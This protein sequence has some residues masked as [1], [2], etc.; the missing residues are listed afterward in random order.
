MIGILGKTRL[1]FGRSPAK[2][3][4]VL[5]P[6]ESKSTF[7]PNLIIFQ[8]RLCIFG[9]VTGAFSMRV[10][11]ILWRFS[12]IYYPLN[13]YR[14]IRSDFQPVCLLAPSWHD[15][16]TFACQSNE[17]EF[18]SSNQQFLFV[19]S[20]KVV[21]LGNQVKCY[22][23]D[24]KMNVQNFFCKKKSYQLEMVFSYQSFENN[25]HKSA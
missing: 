19:F 21:K 13:D 9:Q 15:F 11:L 22:S 18:K 14:M 7:L 20:Q 5:G 10:S 25:I 1:S 16:S 23:F 8:P 12:K 3:C 24:L 4:T 17:S 2:N 6:S